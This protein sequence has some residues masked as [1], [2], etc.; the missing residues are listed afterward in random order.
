MPIVLT[1]LLAAFSILA[2]PSSTASAAAFLEAALL[3]SSSSCVARW[4][5]VLR[6]YPSPAGYLLCNVYCV[7]AVQLSLGAAAL[8]WLSEGGASDGVGLEAAIGGQLMSS[9]IALAI[10]W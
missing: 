8:E 5:L 7:C 10:F 6:P 2:V 4:P 1:L 9:E 3:A